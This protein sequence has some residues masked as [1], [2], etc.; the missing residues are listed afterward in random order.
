[1]KHLLLISICAA[2][3]FA[4]APTFADPPEWDYDV[5]Y[6]AV[7]IKGFDCLAFWFDTS[8]VATE[9][10]PGLGG[11]LVPLTNVTMIVDTSHQFPVVD[12]LL[13]C[14]GSV[15]LGDTA[16]AYDFMTGE[17]IQVVLATTRE[18]CDLRP[19]RAYCKGNGNG[20]VTF[21]AET[22]GGTCDSGTP[23]GWIVTEEYTATWTPGGQAKLN[24]HFRGD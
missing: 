2:G 4:S 22:T 16:I 11:V 19:D 7:V 12:M 17:E 10:A 3:L 6:P 23:T 8:G 15:P 9:V 14:H 21:T 24:C 13:N 1:M 5:F 18:L 20:A